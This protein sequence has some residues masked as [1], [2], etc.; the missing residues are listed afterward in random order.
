MTRTFQRKFEDFICANCGSEVQGD[1][2]T[3]HCPHCL[4]SRHVDISPGD[5]AA[6]CGGLMP[7]IAIE[8]APAAYRILHRCRKC[9]HEKWNRVAPGDDFEALLALAQQQ[10]GGR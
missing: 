7:P 10:A 9:G 4:W 3:N 1:G 2:Y 6:H 5:R 8:G